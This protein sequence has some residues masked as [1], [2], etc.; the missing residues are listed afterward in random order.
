MAIPRFENID[1]LSNLALQIN[2]IINLIIQEGDILLLDQ[3][4]KIFYQ[5]N[6][7]NPFYLSWIYSVECLIDYDVQKITT[8]DSPEI[9]PEIY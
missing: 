2:N 1:P 6:L 3:V 7:I 4:F 5:Y 8:V 9:I